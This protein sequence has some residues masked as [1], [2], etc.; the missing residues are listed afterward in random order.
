[1]DF[2]FFRS[3]CWRP[4]C[5]STGSFV[6]MDRRAI[7]P[8]WFDLSLHTAGP[9]NN[10]PSDTSSHRRRRATD[11]DM[12]HRN[13]AAL[14]EPVASNFP[15]WSVLAISTK[16]MRKSLGLSPSDVAG[17]RRVVC[18]CRQMIW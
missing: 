4:L 12:R 3:D 1:V 16:W 15:F 11:F 18:R 5:R 9:R 2:C 17:W 8:F 10:V 6:W 7:L 14:Y 13:F